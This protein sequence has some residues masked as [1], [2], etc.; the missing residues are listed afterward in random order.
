MRRRIE[1]QMPEWWVGWKWRLKY[2][3]K[4]KWDPVARYVFFFLFLFRKD[5]LCQTPFPLLFD[6]EGIINKRILMKNSSGQNNFLKKNSSSLAMQQDVP[7][8]PPELP[9]FLVTMVTKM[10]SVTSISRC[11]S[12]SQLSIVNSY[13]W[14]YQ[15]MAA[16]ILTSKTT[17]KP[18]ISYG[19]QKALYF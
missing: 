15:G 6:K 14:Y 10:M 19:H 11:Q 8:L 9:L 5:I 1:C 7:L 13:Q 18:A 17:T 16:E 12:T 3:R 2:E 4:W